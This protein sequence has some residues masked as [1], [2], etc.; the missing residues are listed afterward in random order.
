VAVDRHALYAPAVRARL[1]AL[2]VAAVPFLAVAQDEDEVYSEPPSAARFH[3]TAW[4]GSSL[5]T[6]AKSPGAAHAGGEVAYAF[7][8]ADL[9]ILAEGYH[10]GDRARTPWAPVVMARYLQR[11]QTLR[12]IEASLG[13]GLGVGRTKSWIGWYQVALGV[14][15]LEGPIFIAGE[16]GFEQLDL[17]R[18]AA[19]VGVRF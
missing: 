17:L 18:L 1:S 5:D 19:G 15:I 6:T 11:F 9:G 2:L 14:R 7:E 12:G 4:G 10:L 3:V 8:A 13:F 16:L